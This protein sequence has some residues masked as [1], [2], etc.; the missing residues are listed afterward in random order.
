MDTRTNLDVRGN[1]REA[2]SVPVRQCVWLMPLCLLGALGWLQFLNG[3]SH[4]ARP[5]SVP[6]HDQVA[7]TFSLV[8]PQARQ[9]CVAGDFNQWSM[10][11]DCMLR[12]GDGWSVRIVLA[13]G[14][15]SY[16]FVTDKVHW[17][18]D[19]AAVLKEDNGFGTENSV[20]IVE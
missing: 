15:Y 3:C 10:E 4:S 14:R 2:W 5:A 18:P 16:A 9:V 12:S 13:P 8:A 1:K 11:A 6:A 17:Q 19:P 7:V 20:L